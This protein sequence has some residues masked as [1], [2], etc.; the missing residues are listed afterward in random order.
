GPVALGH[1]APLAG[2]PEEP[3]PAR[4]GGAAVGVGIGEA[5]EAEPAAGVLAFVLGGLGGA[6]GHPAKRDPRSGGDGHHASPSCSALASCHAM[7]AAPDLS[8]AASI[9]ARR[10]RNSGSSRA[11]SSAS[12]RALR[13][14]ASAFRSM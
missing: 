3:V 12:S 14:A 5:G 4:L 13:A 11:A 9:S 8:R 1:G 10:A 7:Y 6:G 2:D